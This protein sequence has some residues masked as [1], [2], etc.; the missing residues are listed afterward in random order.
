MES[1]AVLAIVKRC[2]LDWALISSEAVDYEIHKVPDIERKRK[3]ERIAS[4]SREKIMVD[5]AIAS[6]ALEIEKLGLRAVDALHISCAERSSDVMLTT[7][8]EII[9]VA[10]KKNAGININVANPA[11]WLFDVL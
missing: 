2:L 10:I 11:R 1:E 9:K 6:R 5:S 8:D 3:L 7:D 4:I